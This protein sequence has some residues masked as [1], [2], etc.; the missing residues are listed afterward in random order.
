MRTFTASSI[1]TSK[2]DQCRR[3]SRQAVPKC[4]TSVSPNA[5]PGKNLKELSESQASITTGGF[6][7]G[8]LSCM[9]PELLRGAPADGRSD[10]WALGVLLY[11]MSYRQA[12][13]CR[14]NLL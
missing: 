3:D 1:A 6:M 13:L 12:P 11:E 7:A 5:S 14:N 2:A 8:T 9:A 10:I 4:S